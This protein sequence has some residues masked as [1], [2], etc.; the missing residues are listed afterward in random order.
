MTINCGGWDKRWAH[1]QIGEADRR[2]RGSFVQR[3][4]TSTPV[5]PPLTSQNWTKEIIWFN[6][7]TVIATPLVSLY[8]LVTTMF[9]GKTFVFCIVY[10]LFN[11][12]GVLYVHITNSS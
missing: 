12:I 4:L 3:Q 6:L 9:C 2:S 1:H 7:I 8:G 11:M 5:R 10:Y